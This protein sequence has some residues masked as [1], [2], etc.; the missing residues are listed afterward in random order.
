MSCRLSVSVSAWYSVLKSR[1][2][3]PG[4]LPKYFATTL[5]LGTLVGVSVMSLIIAHAF[6]VGV[7]RRLCV[8]QLRYSMRRFGGCWSY[9]LVLTRLL[10]VMPRGIF[11]VCRSRRAM[12]RGIRRLGR[13][14]GLC[15]CEPLYFGS[16]RTS[17]RTCPATRLCAI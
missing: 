17:T 9:L 1:T 8:L 10:L 11:R 15:G 16:D 14:V 2:V 7:F 3:V 12:L 6:G 5:A 13:H 4:R